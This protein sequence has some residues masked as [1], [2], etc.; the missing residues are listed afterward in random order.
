MVGKSLAW[1]VL[2][3]VLGSVLPPLSAGAAD[4]QAAGR[5]HQNLDAVFGLRVRQEILPD[6]YYFDPVENDRNWIR[7]PHPRGASLAARPGH[8]LELRLANEF[9]KIVVPSGV[10]LDLDEVVID[11][12]AW[13]WRRQGGFPFILT[14]GRQDVIWNDGF[15]LL[16]GHPFDGSRTIYQNALR[17]VLDREH[18]LDRAGGHRST[19]SAIPSCSSATRTAPS[20]RPTRPRW[21]CAASGRARRRTT[22]RYQLAGIWKR[23]DD[24]DHRLERSDHLDASRAGWSGEARRRWASW[25]RPPLST[26]MAAAPTAGPSRCRP[27]CAAALGRERKGELGY[28]HYSGRGD[29]VE[30]FI[31]P[32]GRWPKWSELYL[33]TLVGEGGVGLWQNIWPGPV[34]RLSAASSTQ[35]ASLRVTGYPALR[36]ARATGPGAGELFEILGA[37]RFNDELS[38][39]LLWEWLHAGD[40][41]PGQEENAHM[42]RWQVEYE[43]R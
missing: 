40:Y 3:V 12:L 5:L 18:E 17:L 1:V 42:I 23:D 8:T 10:D 4:A 2:A 7:L 20:A 22:L 6:A 26:R 33:Y 11:R 14:L 39:H 9:R 19:P 34:S 43:I 41:P 29:D 30:G 28:L 21:P 25:S 37:Y 36:P 27:T 38:A 31:P 16:E 15:L 32:Y 13:T 35:K 24:P